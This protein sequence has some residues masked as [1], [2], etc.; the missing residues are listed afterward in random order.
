MTTPR[1]GA[2]EP[3][4]RIL[5]LS[6]LHMTGSGLDADG[7]DTIRALRCLLVALDEVDDIDLVVTTGD[8][9]DDG[10]T[11]GCRRVLDM[12]GSLARAREVPHIYT[13]GNHDTRGAFRAVFG[14]GHLAPDDREL[15]TRPAPY[16]ACGAV[17]E[18]G[19][20]R[21]VTLD[22][23]VPGAV[24]GEV[25]P[26]Q[27]DWLERVVDS[28]AP[29]GTVVAMHH[30]PLT[31][32]RHPLGDFLLH[33]VEPLAR[34]LRS[35]DVRAV[36]CGHVHHQMAGALGGIPVL[37]APGIVTRIDLAAPRH[38]MR[39]VLGAGASITELRGGEPP[40]TY[41]VAG[42]DPRAGQLVYRV[43][44]RTGRRIDRGTDM[45]VP[46]LI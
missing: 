28:P 4:T 15:G 1:E 32:P 22:T 10:S 40:L 19:G 20:L 13:T 30:P 26:A 39:G 33:D 8:L 27:L 11:E 36:L 34:V 44:T 38:E 25:G 43:D 18:H 23:L 6:D 12:V 29:R 24:H 16:G 41:A 45:L 9:A 2:A 3:V 42:R 31:L 37:V 35:S 17:S 7:V 14:M 5:H 46:P 21:V